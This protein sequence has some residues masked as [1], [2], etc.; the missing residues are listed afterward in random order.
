MARLVKRVLIVGAAA[1]FALAAL[2]ASDSGNAVRA[3]AIGVAVLPLGLFIAVR[4]PR[5]IY[6]AM[7]LELGAIPF[8]DV[9]GVNFPLGL[10]LAVL[11]AITAVLQL[12]RTGVKLSAL[13][14]WCIALVVASTVSMIVTW[15][16][17]FD[18][19]E[20]L[21]WFIATSMFF[22][23]R[24][25]SPV[26]LRAFGRWFVYGVSAAAVFGA[27][28]LAFDPAGKVLDSL[29]IIGYGS[30]GDNL[31]YVFSA[32]GA[33]VRLTGT[34]I[35]P[36]AGGLFLAIGFFLALALFRGFPRV[37]LCVILLG[38]LGLTLSRSALLSVGVAVLVYVAFRS[39]RFGHKLRGLG[40]FAALG[41]IALMIPAIQDRLLAALDP[42]DVGASARESALAQFPTQVAGHW[43]FGLGWGRI[44][45]RDPTVGQE[46]NFVANS[47]LLTVYRGGLITGAIFTIILIIGIVRSFRALSQN[48]SQL[49][50]VGAGFVGISLVA[51]QLDFPV[52]TIYPVTMVFSVLLAFL[53]E[54]VPLARRQ[55]PM[56]VAL[57]EKVGVT[58]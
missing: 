47:P 41:A 34:F 4:R 46:V 38:A 21:K 22:S 1:V 30:A 23:L 28:L 32:S 3:I 36:N 39:G 8:A 50:I 54:L 11:V 26:D 6:C 17:S 43:L 53:P 19:I 9:P 20:Y 25:L 52:V 2:F 18:T 33:T 44:E 42:S 49:T 37:A 15:T 40:V 29:A 13:E 12:P 45:F 10:V 5:I 14:W 48:R 16:S 55:E 51:L 56:P 58:R 27:A 35:D 7:A 57:P 31:R 24:R